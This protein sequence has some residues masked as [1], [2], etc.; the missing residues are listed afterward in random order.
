MLNTENTPHPR[1]WQQ[2]IENIHAAARDGATRGYSR[3]H[4]N[5]ATAARRNS[6]DDQK[7][8]WMH[9]PLLPPVYCAYV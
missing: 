8:W 3:G 7:W 5:E 9:H 4:G 2:N 6:K 1:T